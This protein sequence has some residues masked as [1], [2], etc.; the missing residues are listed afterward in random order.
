MVPFAAA[1]KAW[2]VYPPLKAPRVHNGF[3][4]HCL[5]EGALIATETQDDDQPGD[6]EKYDR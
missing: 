3:L 4:P 2:T 6:S 1:S 5:T